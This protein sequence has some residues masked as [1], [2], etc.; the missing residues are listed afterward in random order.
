LKKE[1][2]YTLEYLK[3]WIK[4]GKNIKISLDI[5]HLQNNNYFEYIPLIKD[6]KESIVEIQLSIK[7]D[8]KNFLKGNINKKYNFIK[9]LSVPIVLET[10]PEQISD[11]P[12]IIKNLKFWVQK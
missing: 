3:D 7:K 9:D 12:I 10:R 1:R 5:G 2:K 11:L 6:I 4:K 8:Y